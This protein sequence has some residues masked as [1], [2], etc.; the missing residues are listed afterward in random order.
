M[1]DIKIT[2]PDGEERIVSIGDYEVI[3]KDIDGSFIRS[4]LRSEIRGLVEMSEYKQKYSWKDFWE[5]ILEH[6]DK[7]HKV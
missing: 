4:L 1:V 6:F 2:N 3:L 5:K 7:H